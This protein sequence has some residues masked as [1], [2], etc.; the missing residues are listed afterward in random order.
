[1]LTLKKPYII[2]VGIIV[3]VIFFGCISNK[4]NKEIRLYTDK[5]FIQSKFPRIKDIKSVKYYYIEDRDRNI[6]LVHKKFSGLIEIGNQFAVK[7]NKCNWEKSLVPTDPLLLKEG[8]YNFFTS[9]GFNSKYTSMSF[10]GEFYYEK[11]KNL[12]YFNGEY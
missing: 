12:L 7:I 4:D 6:G 9:S 8:E 10:V 1:M 3:V 11:G 5:E 2:I